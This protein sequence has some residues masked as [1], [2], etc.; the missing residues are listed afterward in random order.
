LSHA[1][2]MRRIVE[3]GVPLYQ[4][5]VRAMC[6]QEAAAREQYGIGFLD[7]DV[8]VPQGIMEVDLP[9]G[10]PEQVFFTLDVDGLDP[11]VIAATGTPVPGGLG[12]YQTLSLFQSVAR[13]RRLIGFDLMELA[14]I[15]G[16]HCYDFAAA[17]LVY[18]LIGIQH[19]STT[20]G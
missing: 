5:G 14:P 7:A 19:L 2:V 16:F 4:L 12:W 18:K 15:E 13:Q 10:F 3:A 6:A 9:A 11:S 1:C 17:Q 20:S 8:L